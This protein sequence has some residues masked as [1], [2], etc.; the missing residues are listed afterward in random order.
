MMAQ[1]A[2]HTK[3]RSTF[4][5]PAIMMI[6]SLFHPHLGGAEQQALMLAEQLIKRGM[7][8]SVLTR[9]FKGLPS[10]E[11][12]R[13]VP[14]YRRIR[15]LSRGK[16]FGLSYMV[17]TL[18]FL[19]R[20]RNS[21]DIIHCHLLGF[22]SAVAVLLKWLFGKKTIS[23]VGATGPVSDFL[24]MK[25]IF[26]GNFFLR[27]IARSDR[28]ILLCS[29]SR[30]EALAEGFFPAQLVYIP[31]GVDT[32]CFKPDPDIGKRGN[33]ITFIGRL[34]YL[35]GVD[36][37][38]QAF[39]RLISAGIPARLDILG[40]GPERNNLEIM[41]QQLGINDAV[42]FHGAVHGVAP[43]LQCSALFVLPSLSEGM[44]NVVLEAMACGLPVVA[45]RVGG[46]VDIIED[47]ANG[48]LVDAQRPDQLYEAMQR[49]FTDRQLA[50]RLA[51]QALKTIEQQFS[52]D[53]IVNRYSALYQALMK[54][55]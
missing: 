50:D 16:W 19:F 43:Y 29:K 1:E 23:L 4:S 8:V 40:D 20:N 28:L 2:G 53:T 9:T 7:K 41:S 33:T 37:L 49:L 44:P 21:Y 27:M 32:A 31:N 14:V 25:N 54:S 22:H 5:S 15:T 46:I 13:G 35:K 3:G 30:E 6:V 48:L 55:S 18:W 24:Q 34:D 51:R 17:S 36:I 52:L 47:G 39:S 45:T 12:I 38:L 26:M 11:V 10:F 42:T